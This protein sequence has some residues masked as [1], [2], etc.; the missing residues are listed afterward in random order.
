MADYGCKP[1]SAICNV[2]IKG[3]AE[4]G[5]VEAASR[6]VEEAL[7]LY[8]EMRTRGIAPDLY[9]YNSFTPNLG[10]AGMVEQAG[11]IYEQLQLVGLEPDV[12]TYNALIPLYG[13]SGDPDHAN[14][15]YKNMMVGGCSPM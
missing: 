11:R 10:L 3:F 9:T 6:R 4:T 7:A 5:D 13:T 2:L 8:D 14:A 15:V 1:N 12:F